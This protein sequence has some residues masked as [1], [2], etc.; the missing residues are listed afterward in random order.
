MYTMAE[1]E[2]L[3]KAFSAARDRT[4]RAR[5]DDARRGRESAPLAGA[6]RENSLARFAEAHDE[7][8]AAVNDSKALFD[9]PKSR[10]F[11]GVRIG[12]RKNKGVLEYAD[13]TAT[14]AA[15]EKKFPAEKADALVRVKKTLIAAAIEQ[16][17][18]AELKAIGVTISDDTEL[19]FVK[20]VGDDIDKLTRALIKDAD[21][22]EEVLPQ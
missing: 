22:A 5:S 9:K 18:G 1:I 10:T 21:I 16:L 3:T 17:T 2:V 6:G 14:I 4:R 7:L 15:I 12:W 20:P 19:A 11:H 13:E 8:L